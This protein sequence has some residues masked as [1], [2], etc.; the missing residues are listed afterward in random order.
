MHVS[1]VYTYTPACVNGPHMGDHGRPRYTTG[2]HGRL[3]MGDNGGQFVSRRH[4]VK[5][6]RRGQDPISSRCF[7]KYY[8]YYYYY[9]YYYY[10]YYYY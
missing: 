6:L 10:Y 3:R 9:H 5:P 2:D 8:Y 7:G 1:G 4:F